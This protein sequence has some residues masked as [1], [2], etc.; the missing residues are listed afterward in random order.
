MQPLS[1][2]LSLQFASFAA[3]GAVGTGV[4]YAVLVALVSGL[5][6]SPVLAT[7]IGAV[8][9]AL[10]NYFLNYRLT[11]RSRKRHS[12]AMIK[13]MVVAAIGLGINAAIVKYGVQLA[14]LHY[15]VAQVLAT[16]VVLVW[17]FLANRVWTFQGEAQHAEG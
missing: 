8:C 7:S 2:R 9:G 11:F 10:T 3:I 4:H 5:G 14:G 15:L 1:R 17:G 13:F 6:W 12:E 16:G